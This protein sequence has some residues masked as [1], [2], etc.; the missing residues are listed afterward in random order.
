MST[1]AQWLE[2]NWPLLVIAP[3]SLD[4]WSPGDSDAPH[5]GGVYFLWNGT[6][7]EYVGC[8]GDV[9]YRV[10]QH[11]WSRRIKFDSF[12]VIEI[13]PEP[14][15]FDLCAK[16]IEKSYIEAL[17]PFRNI[18]RTGGNMQMAEAIRKLWV[19]IEPPQG[20]PVRV[21]PRAPLVA[22]APTNKNERVPHCWVNV[23][24]F[25]A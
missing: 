21:P 23:F 8:S 16:V 9:L 10:A 2:E 17:R 22:M 19:P 14:H 4:R 25:C 1:P 6:A 3:E 13:D 18:L 15:S 5:V 12:S 11:V 7:L 20:V 24:R